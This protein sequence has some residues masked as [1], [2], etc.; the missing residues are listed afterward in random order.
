MLTMLTTEAQGASLAIEEA[1]AL[2]LL[3]TG[4]KSPEQVNARLALYQ[5]TLKKR[6]HVVQLLSDSFPTKRDS[7][8]ERAEELW[9]PGLPP[10]EAAGFSP[11]F[12]KFFYGYDVR[13]EVK[14]A[15][16]EETS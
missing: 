8:R 9:G 6:L 15:M 4:V 7:F 3:F 13:A 10:V 11:P 1:A 12:Q 2:E 5:K 16:E 14:K